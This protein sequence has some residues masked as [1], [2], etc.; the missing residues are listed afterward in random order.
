VQPERAPT[1]ST[2]TFTPPRPPPPSALPPRRR[3][4]RLV[5]LAEQEALREE[6]EAQEKAM[7]QE[8]EARRDE[9]VRER[10]AADA[11]RYVLSTQVFDGLAGLQRQRDVSSS[12][13]PPLHM[14]RAQELARAL[15]I[16]Q[17]PMR[18]DAQQQYVVPNAATRK[19]SSTAATP[20]LYES[21]LSATAGKGGRAGIPTGALS[22]LRAH[23]QSER[24]MGALPRKTF[25]IMRIVSKEHGGIDRCPPVYRTVRLSLPAVPIG[26]VPSPLPL[27]SSPLLSPSLPHLSS[28]LMPCHTESPY[29]IPAGSN[30]YM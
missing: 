10:R 25:G 22:T 23:Y 1:P 27:P 11:S 13:R 28:L 24:L 3:A 14:Q 2:P 15:R 17:G 16:A 20:P 7:A 9:A 30:P 12:S 4:S 5:S 8:E 26:F 19:H 29:H 21:A 18:Q 6:E